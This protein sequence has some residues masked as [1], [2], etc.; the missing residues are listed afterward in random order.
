M[1]VIILHALYRLGFDG[2]AVRLANLV[3]LFA[4]DKSLKAAQ[5]YLQSGFTGFP[6]CANCKYPMLSEHDLYH[7]HCST[8]FYGRQ[9]LADILL[10][11][12]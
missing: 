4:R 6:A 1:L 10:T 7:E 2:T 9:S 8:Q 3:R 12:A 11:P 5:D